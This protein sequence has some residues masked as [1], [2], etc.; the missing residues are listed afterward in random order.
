T[1]WYNKY[2]GTPSEG[3]SPPFLYQPYA[4]HDD[5]RDM[6]LLSQPESQMMARLLWQDWFPSIWL[7]EHQQGE[8]GARMFTMPAG[9]P[10]NP[11]VHPLIYR[12]NAI[13]GQ[14]QA[15]ALEADGKKGIMHHANYTSFWEGAMAWSGWWHN[16][17]G[18]LTEAASARIASP[19]VQQR[20]LPGRV[21]ITVQGPPGAADAA[22]RSN[23]VLPPPQDI[24]PRA[25]Y[26]R[27]WLGGTWR[28][29][30][31]VNYEMISTMALLN[32]AADLRETLL[33]Q[34]YDV[35]LST[36]ESGRKGEIGFGNP[37]KEYAVLIPA[38]GQQDSNEVSALVGKLMLGGV[39]VYRS[40]QPFEENGKRWAAGTYVIPFTQVFARYAKDLLEA[41]NYPAVRTPVRPGA[42]SPYDVSAWS[43]GMQFGVKTVFARDP[44]PQSL[45]L[46][47]VI[48][49]PK[50]ELTAGRSAGTIRF[51]YAGAEDAVV[52]NRLLKSGARVSL[53]EAAVQ[54]QASSQGWQ[55][56]TKGF[57]INLKDIAAAQDSG[58]RIRLPRIGLYQSWTA[59]IDEGWTRWVLERYEFP[60]RTLHNA[61]IQAGGLRAKFD[62]IILPDQTVA[63]LLEGQNSPAIPEQ[64]R[65]GLGD[66]GWQELKNFVGL[67]G[68]LIALGNASELPLERLPL[69]VREIKHTLLPDQHNGPGTIL[70]LAIDTAHALGWGMPDRS[71]GFYT[72]SPFFELE[73]GFGPRKAV[74]VARYPHTRIKASG[75]LRGGEYMA[76]RAAVVAVDL[77]PGKVVL[78]GIRP[79]HRAQTHATLPLLFNALYW[80][81]EGESPALSTQ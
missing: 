19:A 36:I 37:N 5:N 29:S 77:K 42:D 51:P 24:T 67:G 26:P 6:F 75:W 61:D 41:Q 62:A 28:L 15:A 32:S 50:P 72:N 35:N 30:D 52:V 47:A 56:A 55:A 7:D 74:A 38:E 70:N 54:A 73:T 33:R 4:G 34:I 21:S 39:Q 12:L 17:V 79:Q 11:N 59:N 78:F 9:D 80:S 49:A 23:Q 10:I 8:T 69:G 13:F 40:R 76:G 43:L 31:I 48:S 20:A 60:Y 71:F 1:N 22:D 45:P 64:Y 57:D 68:T 3:T 81:T 63:S 27:P 16:E 46:D 66:L 18:L 44:L 53:S 25:D 2:L 14:M 58:T 65:G